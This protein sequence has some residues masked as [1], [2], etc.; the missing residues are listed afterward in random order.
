MEVPGSSQQAF[1]SSRSEF[2]MFFATSFRWY[3]QHV[4]TIIVKGSGREGE[5]LPWV[6]LQIIC[7]GFVL[8]AKLRITWSYFCIMAAARGLDIRNR[9]RFPW[10]GGGE[11]KGLAVDFKNVR[12][13]KLRGRGKMGVACTGSI[14]RGDLETWND[15]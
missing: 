10:G 15:V 9:H 1:W 3:P 2:L 14:H 11:G 5:V 13:S 6:D 12:K 4:S 8:Y 7:F